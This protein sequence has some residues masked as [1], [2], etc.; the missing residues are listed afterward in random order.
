MFDRFPGG[1]VK[2]LAGQIELRVEKNHC[3]RNTG[4]RRLAGVIVKCAD[5]CGCR[6]KLPSGRAT[7]SNNTMRIYTQL[8][9]IGSEPPDSG[10]RVGD[11]DVRD[12][13]FADLSILERCTDHTSRG[14]V[15][16]LWNKL[17]GRS[18]PPAATKEKAT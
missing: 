3:I 10:L 11:A 5:Q 18:G 4:D 15:F 17:R 7:R 13:S 1:V 6:S 9:R 12:S 16:G 2:A 14:K 8:S